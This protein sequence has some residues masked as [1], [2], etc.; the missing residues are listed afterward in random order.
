MDSGRVGHCRARRRFNRRTDGPDPKGDHDVGRPSAGGVPAAGAARSGRRSHLRRTRRLRPGILRSYRSQPDAVRRHDP[1]GRS[2][3]RRRCLCPAPGIGRSARHIL[4]WRFQHHQ[5]HR[6]RL[7][8]EVTRGPH[9]WRAGRR[10]SSNSTPFC[11]TRCA[12]SPR[13][14]RSSSASPWQAPCWTIPRDGLPGGRP[15]AGSGGALPPPRLHRAAARH[16]GGDPGAQRADAEHRG[17]HGPGAA[18]R[19]A[20]PRPWT[21]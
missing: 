6:R 10:A 13:R 7:R 14:G 12:A 16:A 15:G 21:C 8:G 18:S 9:Q 2:R 5:S 3:L 1:R 17:G 11:T 20:L 4:R 19:S